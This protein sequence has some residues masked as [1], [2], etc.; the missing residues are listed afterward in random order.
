MPKSVVV[1][2]PVYK[3][4]YCTFSYTLVIRQTATIS[5]TDNMFGVNVNK[6]FQV[7][8]VV[9]LLMSLFYELVIQLCPFWRICADTPSPLF[10][11]CQSI[12]TVQCYCFSVFLY[13]NWMVITRH[14]FFFNWFNRCLTSAMYPV[15]IKFFNFVTAWCWWEWTEKCTKSTYKPISQAFLWVNT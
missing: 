2:Y 11:S 5:V 3:I 13:Y 7:K 8:Y 4:H 12:E 6:D 15:H 10:L 9:T 1:T 14:C